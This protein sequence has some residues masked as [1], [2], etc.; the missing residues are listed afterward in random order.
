MMRKNLPGRFALCGLLGTLVFL[1]ACTGRDEAGPDLQVLTAENHDDRWLTYSPDGS[2]A[3]WMRQDAGGWNVMVGDADLGNAVKVGRS[4]LFAAFPFWSPDGSTVVYGS[5]TLSFVDTWTVPAGGGTPVR[6]TD[7]PGLEVPISWVGDGFQFIAST[8]GGTIT[9]WEYSP[10]TNESRRL[11]PTETGTHW[12]VPSPDGSRVAWVKFEGGQRT[13]WVTDT[14]GAPMQLTT[15]GFEALADQPWSPD[16]ADLL[17]TSQR[18]GTSDVWVMPANGGAA[19][20]L[21]RDVRNDRSPAWSPDGSVVAFISD[22]GKQTDVWVVSAEGGDAWRVTDSPVEESYPVWRPGSRELVFEQAVDEGGLWSLSLEDGTENRL[23]P[24]SL[25]TGFFNLSPD[26]SQMVYQVLRGGGIIDIWVSAVDGSGARPLVTGGDNQT[27]WFSPDGTQVLFISDRSGSLGVWVV[28]VGT[29][30]TRA[31]ADWPTDEREAMWSSDGSAIYFISNREA[32]LGALWKVPAAGGD[33]VRVT[34]ESNVFAVL[35][36][37]YTPEVFALNLADSTGRFSTSRVLPDGSLQSIW[38]RSSTLGAPLIRPGGDSLA[39]DVEVAGGRITAMMLPV[40]GGGEGRPLLEPGQSA[41]LWSPD[42]SRILFY[43]R[44]QVG[45]LGV[46]N[47]KDGTKRVLTN[48][49]AAE[50]GAEWTPDGKTVVF[51]RTTS[52]H[53]MVNT[54]V[55]SEK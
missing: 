47:L 31:V 37:P 19:R 8:Q 12:G 7:Q 2:R 4:E 23:T 24:D 42:G 45:D 6:R 11:I 13:I 36:S 10:A 18:T 50:E 39:T 35:A 32:Q 48:T 20:Q 40:R 16:G 49:P 46:L 1:P 53:E 5:D 17:Y 52:R 38:N 34:R 9:T 14:A 29:G 28:N 55:K 30:E 25:H 33:P 15:E 43:T 27:P 21:T 41:G 22:R 44:A 51:R 54:T 26:G 3:A